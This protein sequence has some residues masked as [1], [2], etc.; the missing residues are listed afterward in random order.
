MTAHGICC[1]DSGAIRLARTTQM[2]SQMAPEQ[3]EL[4]DTNFVEQVL[5]PCDD[6]G[7]VPNLLCTLHD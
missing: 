4:L 6:R 7:G 1:L 3:T 2:G 5:P